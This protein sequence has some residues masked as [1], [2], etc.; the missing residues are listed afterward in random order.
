MD[1]LQTP[2][3][4]TTPEDL[5]IHARFIRDELAPLVASK[6]HSALEREDVS[7]LSSIMF[8]LNAVPMTLEL[9]RFSRIDKALRVIAMGSEWPLEIMMQAEELITKW[10]LALG[11]LQGIHTDLWGPGERLEGLKKKTSQQSE[12]R[13]EQVLSPMNASQ[14]DRLIVE[15]DPESSWIVDPPVDPH[16]SHRYG[17]LG[18][19]IG[20]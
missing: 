6:G 7:T 9:L 16:R 18:F 2:Q 4:G 12:R 20:A 10:E 15:K 1:T 17:H 14:V 3:I 8:S 11:S 19:T 13:E 5:R